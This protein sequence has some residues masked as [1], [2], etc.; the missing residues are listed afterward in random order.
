MFQEKRTRGALICSREIK[1][2]RL[3]LKRKMTVGEVLVG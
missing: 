3:R 2:G 1:N